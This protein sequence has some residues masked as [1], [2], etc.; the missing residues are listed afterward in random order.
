[1][2]IYR[3]DR[4]T[5]RLTRRA[6]LK[7]GLGATALAIA[8]PAYL[9]H[10]RAQDGPI[11]IGM[12]VPLS[13]PYSTEAQ[14]QVRCA[15]IAIKQFNEAGGLNGRMAELLVRDDKLDPG[16]AATRTLELIE[17]DKV[18]FL[19]GALSASVQLSVNQVASERGVIYN[20]ISQSD[21]INEKSDFTKYTFHEAMNPHMT[22]GAVGRYV[23]PKAEG[24]R[25][26][27]LLA[28][29]AYGHEML[30]GF[31]RAGEEFGIE[32]VEEIRHPIGQ[33]DFSAFFPRIQAAKPD[34]LII[35]NFGRDLLNSVIQANDF[36]LKQQMQLATPVLLFNQVKAGGPAAFEGVV[37]GANYYWKLEDEHES[38]KKLNEAYR[39]A[40]NAV[41]SD[42]AAYG[43]AGIFGLLEGAK[44]AGSTEADAVIAAMEEMSYDPYKGAQDFRKC[45]HQSVQSVLVLEAKGQMED[46]WDLFNIVATENGDEATLRTC[47]ELGHG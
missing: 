16:E 33:A 14:D 36:G 9:R 42:Y 29:Y 1:M 32:T 19:C 25:A 39:S 10:A 8:A 28:D 15:E 44:K 12:P 47:Q 3:F 38:A 5:G 46:E 2:T 37:G 35:A 21:T 13:G 4:Q 22:A 45:D 31:Q 17:S 26:A 30:R 43:F 23:F 41:P 27:Y 24:K 18:N 20:S 11:K 34:V 7:A 6:M 40:H